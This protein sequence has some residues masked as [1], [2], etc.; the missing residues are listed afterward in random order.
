VGIK[1][2]AT[3]LELVHVGAGLYAPPA[4][5]VEATD[6]ELPLDIS[7]ELVLD[8]FRYVVGKLTASQREGG[9]AVTGEALRAI[10][11][12][13]LVRGAVAD[14][15]RLRVNGEQT[16]VVLPHEERKRLA[17]NGPTDETLTWVARIYL[18][19]ELASDPPAKAVKEAMGIPTST[20]GYWIRRAKDKGLMDPPPVQEST[21]RMTPEELRESQRRYLDN[22]RAR[23]S[24]D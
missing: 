20:A 5:W 21:S 16:D 8:G 10:P 9:A 7:A 15:V 1:T 18:T 19:A 11:V 22:L 3:E 6:T 14:R 23:P 12:Q 17:D 2:K 4:I 13:T 24:K